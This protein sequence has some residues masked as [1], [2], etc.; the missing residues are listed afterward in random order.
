[1]FNRVKMSALIRQWRLQSGTY[2]YVMKYFSKLGQYNFLVDVPVSQL[3][4]F[5]Q[6]AHRLNMTREYYNYYFTTWDVDRVNFSQLAPYFSGAN[7]TAFSLV[8]RDLPAK[9]APESRE[10][11]RR[12]IAEQHRLV[13][14]MDDFLPT[15][16]ALMHD[17]LHML[18]LGLQA[19]TRSKNIQPTPLNCRRR[20]L[21]S[22]G[23]TLVNYVVASSTSSNS[24]GQKLCFQPLS[25]PISLDNLGFRSDFNL[26]IEERLPYTG[27]HQLGYWAQRGGLVIT[28]NY[29]QTKEEIRESLRKKTL[30]V[31]TLSGALHG[32]GANKGRAT[33]SVR[34]AGVSQQTVDITPSSR[35][36][37]PV[38]CLQREQQHL[39]HR[40]WADSPFVFYNRTLQ[41]G[42]EPSSDP[43]DWDGFCIELLKQISAKLGFNIS[44]HLVRDGQYGKILGQGPD[45]REVWNGMIG[46]LMNR[47]ADLAIASLTITYDRE[48]VIDFTTP[49]MSLG[50][51]IIYKKPQKE[52]PSLFSFLHPLSRTVSSAVCPFEW[53]NPHACHPDSDVVENQ[54]NITNSLWFTIGSLMQQG[55]EMAPRANSTRIVSGSWWFFT[56][57]M[58]SSYTANLAAF[59]TVKR[60]KSPIENVEDLSKQNEIMYGILEGGS[61]FHF[62]QKATIPTYKS[63]FD[64]M[65]SNS[66]KC[67]VKSTPEGIERVLNENYA[68]ILEST[69]NEYY[70]QRNCKLMQVGGLLDSKG[71]GIGMPAGS[72]Y[73]DVFSETI[74]ELQKSQA[75]ESLRQ[76]WWRKFNI[77]K[78]CD[79]TD[80]PSGNRHPTNALGLEQIGGAFIIL[81]AGM[82][83]SVLCAGI[84]F[85]F[86]HIKH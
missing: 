38:G 43:K 3:M 72:P 33:G 55:S 75:I 51:S 23:A 44:L 8:P 66:A 50:L 46:E 37:S 34:G 76:K 24:D 56:L 69:W 49:F 29:T 64:F 7:L 63:M 18:A 36:T 26:L 1:M 60:M 81:T 48:R 41:P 67:F 78:P 74:L 47:T 42:Q 6:T 45:G 71:Y 31:T 13:P 35:L 86:K 61:T 52:K 10:F 16:A 58:I 73:V 53:Y 70:T 83:L 79:D 80:G 22:D 84:E 28:K 2:E 25:G 39:L 82:L 17:A 14:Y 62:F 5:F 77:S 85:C 11:V 15:E 54:F 4:Q 65:S 59:L 30:R 40:L 32:L 20:N 9:L 57:I 27:A 12:L 68:F 21:W 19:A